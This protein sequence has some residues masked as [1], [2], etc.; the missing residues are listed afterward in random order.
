MLFRSAREQPVVPVSTLPAKLTLERIFDS[1]DL[2]GEQPRGL[3]ISPDGKLLTLLR[4]RKNDKER[5]DL[6][7]IDT[8]SGKEWMLVDSLKTGSGAELSE[9]EKMQRERARIGGTRGIVSY[10]WAADAKHII[11]PIDGDIYLATVGGDTVRLTNT[12]DG[13]LNATVSPKGRWLSFVRGGN[14]FVTDITTRQEKQITTG[15]SD[16]ISWGVAEFA[17]QEEMGRET[18][19]WW[20]PDEIGR[21]HV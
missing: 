15:A 16:T 18:G 8:T 13:E 1:P 11:V 20:S 17:A 12:P 6:W 14:L 3:K 4:N 10:D 21:A 7:A 5:F 19:H 2:A 9:A